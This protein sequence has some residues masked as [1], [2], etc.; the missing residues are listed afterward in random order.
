MK[1]K[2]SEKNIFI[3]IVSAI[4]PA[5]FCVIVW[6][7][8]GI[9]PGSSRTL[10]ST[11]LFCEYYGFYESLKSVFDGDNSI[12]YNWSLYLGYNVFGTYTADISLPFSCLCFC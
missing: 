11:D 10:L 2:V 5:A 8:A 7:I 1:K 12:F 4:L 6:A 3:Y 9:Y